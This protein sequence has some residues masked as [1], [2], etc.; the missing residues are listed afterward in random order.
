[1][2]ELPGT[3]TAIHNNNS[4]GIKGGK[5]WKLPL[6]SSALHRELV[7]L[8]AARLGSLAGC[9]SH[10]YHVWRVSV[11]FTT[12]CWE[13]SSSGGNTQCRWHISPLGLGGVVQSTT[14]FSPGKQHANS[15]RWI[16]PILIMQ[17]P[18]WISS[19]LNLVTHLSLPQGSAPIG[20]VEPKQ[21]VK[22]D[23]KKP[24]NC[25]TRSAMKLPTPAPE[26][27]EQVPNCGQGRT[28]SLPK[29]TCLLHAHCIDLLAPYLHVITRNV[30]P[31]ATPRY[32]LSTLVSEDQ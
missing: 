17:R 15:R 5:C 7:T 27:P 21:D 2:K 14:A 8:H 18:P 32:N 20:A 9:L 24:S 4:F 23:R 3:C 25:S 22:R 1:M 13:E 16:I 26:I 10:T 31:Q 19:V 30:L 11:K 29:S 12:G 28:I 6:V